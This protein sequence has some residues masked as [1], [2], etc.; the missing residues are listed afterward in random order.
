MAL[1]DFQ[2]LLR[3]V[4]IDFNDLHAVKQGAAHRC[5]AIGRCDEQDLGQV[6]VHIEVVIVEVAV[7]LGIKHLEQC[8][9]WVTLEVLSHLVYLIEHDNGIVAATLAQGSDDAARHR[10][11]VGAAM[12]SD[13]GFVMQAAQ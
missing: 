5:Q 12:A 13:L 10:A 3:D 6:I 2:F 9:R 7:L 1:S 11:D 4:T 8:R